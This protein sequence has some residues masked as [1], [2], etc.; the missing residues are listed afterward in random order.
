MQGLFRIGR[1]A[2]S[3]KKVSSF[4]VTRN[5]TL[6]K[7]ELIGCMNPHKASDVEESKRKD[8]EIMY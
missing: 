4:A 8:K 1:I 6:N 2:E 7:R 3:K 5:L